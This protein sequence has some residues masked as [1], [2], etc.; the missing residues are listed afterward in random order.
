MRESHRLGFGDHCSK[1]GTVLNR[2]VTLGHDGG[3]EGGRRHVQLEPD[4]PRG[5]DHPINGLE[6]ATAKLVATPRA[7]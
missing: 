6:G 2:L 7:K 4:T 3:H 1:E 5:L